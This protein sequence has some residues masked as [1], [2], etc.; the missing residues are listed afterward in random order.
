MTSIDPAPPA[1]RLFFL[2]ALRIAAFALLV[3]YHVGMY[4]VSWPWHVK[5]ALAGPGLEP[6]MQLS[7]PWRL[8]L[9]FVLSGVAT[10]F[11]LRR[12]GATA[13]LLRQRVRRLALPVL[14]GMALVVPPQ[15][16]FEVRQFHGYRGSYVEFLQLYFGA[17]G[18]FCAAGRGCLV[19]PTWNH[20]WFVVYLLVY[21]VLWWGLVRLW[22]ALPAA[23]AA[24]LHRVLAGA[25]LWAW[26]VA[27][28]A[29]LRIALIDRFAPTHALVDDAYLHASY[30]ALF[31][32]GAAMARMVSPWP[33]FERTRWISLALALAGWLLMQA[34]PSWRDA[35]GTDA[36]R[37]LGR[38]G[39]ATAQWCGVLAALGFAH[40]HWPQE[41]PGRRWLSEAVFPV[42][43][44]HQS[45]II[46]LAVALA[47]LA[48]PATVE[49]ALLITA[50]FGLS[51]A[52][53]AAVCRV[54]WLRPWFGLAGRMSA[55]PPAPLG[56]AGAR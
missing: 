16:Y 45:V 1:E 14:L 53:Y 18:G 15:A 39:F 22:P 33:R 37:A 28:L 24:S 40:R 10:S 41:F 23:T 20:L 25:G 5:S 48:L 13:T 38:A 29:A 44:V 52:C 11:M 36:A 2:D 4:Y 31:I 7:S 17:F 34:A 6:W 55:A 30:F 26:P 27:L 9:L 56:Q 50:T 42:Y 21:T 3:L 19:L 12:D 35:L 51:L 8:S 54:A 49:A 32:A 43:I 46:V 47:P